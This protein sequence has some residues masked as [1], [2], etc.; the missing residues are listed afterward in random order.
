MVEGF[1]WGAPLYAACFG[2][3]GTLATPW[4]GADPA[5]LL[6]SHSYA[7]AWVAL[8]AGVVTVMDARRVYVRL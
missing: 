1:G 4:I 6:Q 8:F 2:W 5:L 3:I 7:A